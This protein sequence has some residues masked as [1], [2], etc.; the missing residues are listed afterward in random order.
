MYS[1]WWVRICIYEHGDEPS[2]PL[3]LACQVLRMESPPLN[4]QAKPMAAPPR[5]ARPE[6]WL[7]SPSEMNSTSKGLRPAVDPASPSLRNVTTPLGVDSPASVTQGSLTLARKSEATLGLEDAIPLGLGRRDRHES[8]NSPR[9]HGFPG[10]SLTVWA[11]S[12]SI[13]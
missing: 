10:R 11:E 3:E 2:P 6:I 5:C 9:G 7:K 12:A 8:G 4:H 1:V 13:R